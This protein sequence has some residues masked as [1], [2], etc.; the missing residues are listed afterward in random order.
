MSDKWR[1]GKQIAN[2]LISAW[3]DARPSTD[4]APQPDE[5]V[6]LVHTQELAGLGR[7]PRYQDHAGISLAEFKRQRREL[8]EIELI[9]KPL[10]QAQAVIAARDTDE[11]VPAGTIE[12]TIPRS[13]LRTEVCV[14]VPPLGFASAIPRWRHGRIE[15][16]RLW[17]KGG[18]RERRVSVEVACASREW[19]VHELAAAQHRLANASTVEHSALQSLQGSAYRAPVLF[20]SHRWQSANHPDPNGETLMRLREIGDAYLIVD[21]CSFP[22]PP[23]APNEGKHL[24]YI[25]AS[26]GDLMR[27]VVVMQSDDYLSRGWCVYEYLCACLKGTLVCDEIQDE[28]FSDLHRWTS[29]DAPIPAD[30]FRDGVSGRMTNF[31]QESVLHSINR[32][33]PQFKAARYTV[34]DDRTRVRSMLRAEL[35]RKLPPRRMHDPLLSETLSKS[36]QPDELERAFDSQLQWDD[37]ETATTHPFGVSVAASLGEGRR[38]SFKRTI[39]QSSDWEMSRAASAVGHLFASKHTERSGPDLGMIEA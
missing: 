2:W 25:L 14:P 8:R 18:W 15:N 4:V 23:F 21:Y 17:A 37:M 34:E 13:I 5:L 26:M 39:T 35:L 20:I 38:R 28:R 1:A 19:H 7:L 9:C 29:T 24:E 30:L 12:I 22:Q 11:L 27:N 3:L 16:G 31:I 36:W 33:L 10:V 6:K 32:L